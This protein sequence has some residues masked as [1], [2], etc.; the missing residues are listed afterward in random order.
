MNGLNRVLFVN[1]PPQVEPQ[2]EFV[3]LRQWLIGSSGI[4]ERC[5]RSHEPTE[6]VQPDGAELRR[7]ASPTK[8]SDQGFL[9]EIRESIE[10]Q[11]A[12][13]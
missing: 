1:Q 2:F 13:R 8:L 6:Q 10:V 12:E 3:D 9:Q 7:V 4:R 11:V 5:F